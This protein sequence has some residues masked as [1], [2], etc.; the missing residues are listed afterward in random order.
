M[1]S[2][3]T[4]LERRSTPY[5]PD[6]G[7][8]YP[9]R[10]TEACQAR[11]GAN[12]CGDKGLGRCVGAEEQEER[13]NEKD[14]TNETTIGRSSPR[15][16]DSAQR[17]ELRGGAAR[18]ARWARWKAEAGWCRLRLSSSPSRLIGGETA[19][20]ADAH[21]QA[22]RRAGRM[23]RACRMYRACGI[24]METEDK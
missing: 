8:D 18:W 10:M 15:S 11:Q 20:G 13:G 6:S 19:L 17:W 4:V 3:P 12:R 24:G 9:D 2:T 5:V 21:G 1:P 23:R 7:S 22:G 16:A 14:M